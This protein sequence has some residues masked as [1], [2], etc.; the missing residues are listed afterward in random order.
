MS[1]SKQLKIN[2][3]LQ[4]MP[5]GAVLLSSWLQDQGCRF[6]LQKRYR[7]SGWLESV[8]TGAMIRAGDG[9]GYSRAQWCVRTDTRGNAATAL[10][11]THACAA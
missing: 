8:R 11:V 2:I 9:V 10:D 5:S 7:K 1:F 6:N 3:F 4:S